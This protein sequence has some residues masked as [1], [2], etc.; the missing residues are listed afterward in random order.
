[1]S[2]KYATPQKILPTI[3][4]ESRSTEFLDEAFSEIQSGRIRDGMDALVD[5]L[6]DRYTTSTTTEWA[7][8]VQY[9]L[10]PHP[11]CKLLLQDPLTSYSFRRPR[12]YAG[13]A[14]LLDRVFNPESIDFSDTTSI[15]KKLYQYTSRTPLCLAITERLK[16]LARMIDESVAANSDARILSVASGHCREL[17]FSLAYKAGLIKEMIALDHDEA[18]LSQLNQDY[19]NVNIEPVCQSV[20]NLV[21]HNHFEQKFDLI[22]SSG[23]YDYLNTRFANKLTSLLFDMLAPGGKLVLINIDTDY[24]EIGYMEG[25]MNWGLIGRTAIDLLELAGEIGSRECADIQLIDNPGTRSHF[26][27]MEITKA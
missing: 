21:R 7:Q 2:L 11:V 13:D 25:F 17:D 22:Y 15:G 24:K 20:A 12:G 16:L 4:R 23:L 19:T 6:Y 5:E 26:H 27:V 14:H 10:I 3:V 9:E 8:L 1:M 18:S